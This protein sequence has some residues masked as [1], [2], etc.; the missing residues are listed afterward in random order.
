[1]TSSPIFT[2]YSKTFKSEEKID[3][4]LGSTPT[5]S[6][7]LTSCSEYSDDGKIE[8]RPNTLLE[9]DY[10]IFWQ[11]HLFVDDNENSNTTCQQQIGRQRSRTAEDLGSSYRQQFYCE[12]QEPVSVRQRAMTIEEHT[13]ERELSLG[14]NAH[15]ENSHES[16][17]KRQCQGGN[18][19]LDANS[20]FFRNSE[21]DFVSSYRG[22]FH[23]MTQEVPENRAERRQLLE[24]ILTERDSKRIT[25]PEKELCLIK[26]LGLNQ[27]R[28][29]ES[30]FIGSK[31]QDLRKLGQRTKLGKLEKELISADD[32]RESWS[33]SDKSEKKVSCKSCRPTGCSNKSKRI[34]K[35]R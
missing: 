15:L 7:A 30:I 23:C 10:P 29:V 4:Y 35:R 34:T 13:V 5:H 3:L 1:M 17:E 12:A 16:H 8:E 11:E 25:K 31:L 19:C 14:C 33:R 26:N 6:T 24:K 32:E 18:Y 9:I 28:L 2:A 27:Q 20:Q 21:L 22:L